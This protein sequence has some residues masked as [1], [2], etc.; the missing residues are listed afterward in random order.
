MCLDTDTQKRPTDAI[1]TTNRKR[2]DS[3]T[4]AESVR[5]NVCLPLELELS[6]VNLCYVCVDFVF[7]KN[8]MRCSGKHIRMD[9]PG[10]KTV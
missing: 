9:I 7:K 6:R 2:A 5:G 8:R 10:M 1:V 4:I 3:R